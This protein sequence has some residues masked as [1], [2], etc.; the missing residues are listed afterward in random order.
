M[1]ILFYCYYLTYCDYNPAATTAV[2]HKV[3]YVVTEIHLIVNPKF[4][5]CYPL[6]N[7]WAPAYSRALLHIRGV[8]DI[9]VYY[10]IPETTEK[11]QIDSFVED[12]KA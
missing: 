5:K 3:Q 6:A 10:F 1:L 8:P 12:G 9:D 4:P 2:Q 7:R 11:R